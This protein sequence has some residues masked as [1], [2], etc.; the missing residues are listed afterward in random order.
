MELDNPTKIKGVKH[1]PQQ[2]KSVHLCL[3]R[4]SGKEWGK[5]TTAVK[6]SWAGEVPQCG[7]PVL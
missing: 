1:A 6:P 5:Q 2:R 4:I 3:L 7:K